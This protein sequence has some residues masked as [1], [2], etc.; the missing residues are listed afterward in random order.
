[1]EVYIE[2]WTAPV[3]SAAW[4]TR[5]GGHVP[6]DAPGASPAKPWEHQGHDA[7]KRR[8]LREGAS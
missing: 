3:Q 4:Q 5:D 1:M 6:R 7:P 8:M 2:L